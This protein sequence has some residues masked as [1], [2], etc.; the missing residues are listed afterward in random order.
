MTGG[1]KKH[2]SIQKNFQQ[3]QSPEKL[4]EITPQLL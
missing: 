3:Q 2:P 4:L 1:A